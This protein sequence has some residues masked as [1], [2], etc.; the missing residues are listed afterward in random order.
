MISSA[1]Y[2]VAPICQRG[3]TRIEQW[4]VQV[5]S[6]ADLFIMWNGTTIVP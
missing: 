5:K 3:K 2:P 1:A 4:Q 6:E